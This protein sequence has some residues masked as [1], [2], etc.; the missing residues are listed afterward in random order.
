MF[1]LFGKTYTIIVLVYV[2]DIPVTVSS[3]SQIDSLIAKLHS[4]FT[5]T[6]LGQLSYFLRVEV[7][8]DEISIHLCQTKYIGDLIERT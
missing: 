5:L 3:Q 6:D 7:T 4:A 2:D 8:Y 1:L